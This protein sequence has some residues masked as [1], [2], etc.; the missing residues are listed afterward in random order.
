VCIGGDGLFDDP[1]DSP[2]RCLA[3]E[4]GAN[5][6]YSLLYQ[7]MS[8]ECDVDKTLIAD[9]THKMHLPGH[10]CIFVRKEPHAGT[11]VISALS[12]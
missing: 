11:V 10:R 3:Q 7:L 2:D 5:E 6:G 8:Q 9:M 12:W 1:E 4:P